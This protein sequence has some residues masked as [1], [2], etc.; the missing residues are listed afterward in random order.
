MLSTLGAN[1][2]FR[3][4]SAPRKYLIPATFPHHFLNISATFPHHFLNISAL[5]PRVREYDTTR[6]QQDLLY[7]EKKGK[8]L[9]LEIVT[10]ANSRAHS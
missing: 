6:L 3:S 10:M 1:H 5:F 2:H 7:K 4:I 8:L 9:K